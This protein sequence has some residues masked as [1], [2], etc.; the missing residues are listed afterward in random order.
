MRIKVAAN[1][2]FLVSGA[3]PLRRMIMVADQKGDVCAWR[4]DK[5]YPVQD[6]YALCRCGRSANPP[7]CDG[8]HARFDFDGT[9]HAR[10]FTHRELA[11]RY[12]GPTLDLTDAG[13]FCASARFCD[14]AGGTW[15]LTR[16]SDTPEARQTAIQEVADC[17]SGRLVIWD[18]DGNVIEPAFEPSIGV[19]VDPQAGVSGPLWVRGGIPIEAVDGYV[20]EI[21]NRV[22]LCRCGKSRNMPLCD[23]SHMRFKFRA[24]Y[25]LTESQS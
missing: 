15:R 25:E 4:E 12:K 3:V 24:G 14:R 22:T 17:P 23:G 16:H 2:P 9:E 1:G 21:R 18:K 8:A 20:Y 10:R 7:F 6:H 11:Q 5:V 13:E 19:V